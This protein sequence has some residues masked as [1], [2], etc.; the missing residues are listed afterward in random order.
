MGCRDH[1][2]STD[3]VLD[4]GDLSGLVS[5]P[6]Q[7]WPPPSLAGLLA[8]R[9]LTHGGPYAA[10]NGNPEHQ[11]GERFHTDSS[12]AG[13]AGAMREALPVKAGAVF[14]FRVGLLPDAFHKTEPHLS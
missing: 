7:H 1:P 6:S 8:A 10:A 14:S 5:S 3:R 4:G 2:R 12:Q 13:L 9:P 11:R